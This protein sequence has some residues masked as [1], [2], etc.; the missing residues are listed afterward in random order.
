MS[1]NGNGKVGRLEGQVALI[2]G[3]G[4]GIGEAVALE[5]ARHGAQLFLNS[6]TE[7][8]IAAVAHKCR[9]MGA[10]CEV[11]AADISHPDL[12]ERLVELCR[13]RFGRIDVLVNAA[14]V[15]GSIG[16]LVDS[17]PQ[18]WESTIRTNLIGS[19]NTCR[20]ALK[21]M[22]RVKS[23]T[24]INFSGGGATSP[25]P[26]LSAYGVSKAAVVRFTETLAEEVRSSGVT[27][28]AV[29]PGMVDTS[30][31]DAVLEAGERAGPQFKRSA[32][33]RRGAIHGNPPASA[34]K[35]AA[36][37]AIDRPALLTGRLISAVHDPWQAW[38]ADGVTA[39]EGTDWYTLR[40]LDPHTV[41]ALGLP[42]Q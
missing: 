7:T 11:V 9:A 38:E 25:L 31:H 20:G 40:R 26:N 29:A 2:T 24:I 28:Y 34:A 16:P 27:V 30:I 5:F 13:M 36:F 4:R 17:R 6:R 32:D 18:E 14:A 22:L 10:R 12:A 33:L 37:L 23:G 3:A 19:V 1:S 41:N 8:Q 21:A 39:I 35:L 42:V 15:M